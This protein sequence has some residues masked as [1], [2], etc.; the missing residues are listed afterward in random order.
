MSKPISI[1]IVED[2]VRMRHY[3]EM[4]LSDNDDT[5]ICFSV[6]TLSSAFEALEREGAPAVC[7][8]DMQLPDGRGTE[9]VTRL[10]EN[11]DAHALILTILGDKVSVMEAL[12][13]GADGYLL[14]DSSPTLII[15]AIRDVSSGTNPMSAQAS[16]HLIQ[17][18][19]DQTSA[20]KPSVS[21][22]LTP[23]EMDVLT[24]FT[25]GFT[26]SETAE[27]LGISQHTVKDHVKAIY[28]KMDVNSR[29]EAIF[30]A[31]SLGW[32]TI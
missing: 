24:L 16:S 21:P 3:L 19:K 7:L 30:E 26:Y 2:D 20:S 28:S 22:P 10:K 29:S 8:V 9:F 6:A 15:E 25:K 23:R 11:D 27:K 12:K 18:L 31:I 1:G 13:A 32:V 14:K 17:A 4:V 5:K